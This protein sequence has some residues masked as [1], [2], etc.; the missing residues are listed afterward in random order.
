MLI[1]YFYAFVLGTCIGSF[2]NVCVFRWLKN[3]SVI[4]KP[5]HCLNCGNEIK[6]YDNIPIISYLILKGK[7]RNCHTH[8]SIQ[9]PII[10]FLSGLIFLLIFYKFGIS[11]L[12]L[13]YMFISYPVQILSAF[14]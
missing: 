9:Y 12:C 5:S 3:E 14:H 11:I 8:I 6:W 10:E 7:C 4:F 13:K 2:S 1:L